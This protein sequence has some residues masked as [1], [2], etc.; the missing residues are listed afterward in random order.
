MDE[1]NRGRT[2]KL[3]DLNMNGDSPVLHPFPEGW[4]FVASRADLGAG[5][6]IH[7]TWLG[8]EIVAWC[9]EQGRA[10][11]ADAVCPHLGSSLAPEVGSRVREGRLV[12]PFHGFEYDATGQCVATPYAP[13]PESACLKVY[14]TREVAG[15]VFGWYGIRGRPPQWELPE[16]AHESPQPG[17]ARGEPLAKEKSGWSGLRFH[18]FRFAGHPQETTEN[19]VDLAHLRYVHGYDNVH[20]WGKVKID[21]AYLRN[22]FDF[23][24]RVRIGGLLSPAFAVSAVAHVFGLGYSQV[25]FEERGVGYRSRLWVLCTPV[26]GTSV[27]LRIVSQV[28]GLRRPNG[29]GWVLRLLPLRTRLNLLN[30]F[31]LRKEAGYVKEDIVIWRRKQYLPRPR[32]NHADGEILAYRR[33]C[34]Q[35]YPEANRIEPRLIASQ[36]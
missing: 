14:P 29:V 28:G 31:T 1:T 5:N 22:R 8:E 21:G 30:W 9:D 11:V 24:A 36:T 16:V 23:S 26:D 10:C 32:L 25:D 12:C 15:M 17:S 3:G 6:L 20:Q 2:V 34:Q 33:Y 35:F 7:K 27:E 4:Y 19:S 18:T 13:P